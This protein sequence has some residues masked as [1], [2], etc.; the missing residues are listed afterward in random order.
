[1]LGNRSEKI[2]NSWRKIYS[3]VLPTIVVIVYI[4]DHGVN[5]FDIMKSSNIE[6]ALDSAIT[7]VSIIISFFGVLL[8]ILISARE[9]SKLI[10][11][12]LDTIQKDLFVDCLKQMILSGL[13][14][15]FISAILYLNDI[16]NERLNEFLV[17]CG[18]W[19]LV[20]FMSLTYR[21][22]GIL[23]SLFIYQ[24]EEPNKKN[25]QEVVGERQKRLNEK[26]KN[27]NR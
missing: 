9:K 22:I 17:L 11:Y 3:Y 10:N 24:K 8:T 4:I 14:V 27:M 15:V 1:M 26:I 20:C 5:K 21:F 12:F 2:K 25:N 23:L 18:I 16:L 19:M 7:F 6:S 13:S